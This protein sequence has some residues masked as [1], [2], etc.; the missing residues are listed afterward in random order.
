MLQV[1]KLP[2][3]KKVVLFKYGHLQTLSTYDKLCLSLIIPHG[4][5]DMWMYPIQKYALN[6]G[7]SF[8]FF[9]FQPIRIQFLFLFLYSLYHVKNDIVV[10]LPLQLLYSL[11]LHTSWI[12]FP[13]WALTYFAWIHVAL[14]Y[15]RVIPF[16][17]MVQLFSL[18]MAHVF[19][20]YL[21]NKFE[22]QDLHFGGTW[23]PIV[24]GHIM[25][26]T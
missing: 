25:T 6:Y 21:L 15:Y 13:S 20:Y 2:I 22:S 16:L 5:T 26:N 11:A 14:H 12:C 1:H 8:A 9:M 7:S 24:I 17:S 4:S 23:V 10:K 18:A 3:L 19:V